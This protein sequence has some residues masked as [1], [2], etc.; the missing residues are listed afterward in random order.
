[1]EI[2]VTEKPS[3]RPKLRKKPQKL[4]QKQKQNS[5]Q[6][7]IS[8][9]SQTSENLPRPP[10]DQSVKCR[11]CGLWFTLIPPRYSHRMEN[12]SIA[13]VCQKCPKKFLQWMFR[14]PLTRQ[15]I[16][17]GTLVLAAIKH[18]DDSNHWHCKLSFFFFSFSFFFGGGG[19]GEFAFFFLGKKILIF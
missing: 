12:R 10:N 11:V 5:Q 7:E 3:S 4:R 9:P 18:Q 6:K 15:D 13:F 2:I 19:G 16:H 17:E 1:M 14:T 8:S